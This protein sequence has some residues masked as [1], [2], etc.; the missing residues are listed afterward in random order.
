MKELSL[1]DLTLVQGGSLKSIVADIG[2]MGVGMSFGVINP[3]LGAIMGIG[4]SLAVF[5]YA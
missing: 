2:C 5:Y 4:C 3:L 1:N